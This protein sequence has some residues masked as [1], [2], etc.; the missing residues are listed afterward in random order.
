M[1]MV[2]ARASAGSRTPFRLLYSARGPR[3]ALYRAELDRRSADGSGLDVTYA[4]TREVPDGW[5]RPPARVDAALLAG[6]VW[7]PE[8]APAVF[9]CGPTG[10]TPL[11]SSLRVFEAT[12]ANYGMGFDPIGGVLWSYDDG[13]RELISLQ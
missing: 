4:Y 1:A 6:A 3:S 12:G 5:E 10:A 13:T 7:P 11:S 8:R 2:R 9:V